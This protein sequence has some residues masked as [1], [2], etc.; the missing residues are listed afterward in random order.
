MISY[1]K[2]A[3]MPCQEAHPSLGFYRALMGGRS[4]SVRRFPAHDASR[5]K[6]GF[7]AGGKYAGLIE[8]A[9]QPAKKSVIAGGKAIGPSE[10]STSSTGHVSG[11]PS[12][13]HNSA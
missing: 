6:R 2:H 11:A 1:N 12:T 5:W 4:R 8:P 13:H 7:P 3:I 10:G 9:S